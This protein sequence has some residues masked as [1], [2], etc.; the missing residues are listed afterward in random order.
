MQMNQLRVPIKQALI[1]VSDKTGIV[2]FAQALIACNIEI[3]STGG[4]SQLLRAANIPVRDV[5]AV[6]G[7]AEI[8]DGRVK[9]LHPQIHGGILGQRDAHAAIAKTH[10]IDWID[11]VIV[12]LYPFAAAIKKVDATLAEA[13]E[14]I[15]VGGPALIRAAAKNMGWVAV[16]V[17]PNDYPKIL[18]ELIADNGLSFLTRQQ[19]AI[20]AFAY[21]AHYD[22]VIYDYLMSSVSQPPRDSQQIFPAQLNLSLKKF[23]DLRYGEN[24][25]QAACAYRFDN[26]L[27]GVLSAKQYQGKQLSYNNLTDAAAAVACVNEFMQ[28][29]CVVVKHTNPCGAAMANTIAAAF[30]AAFYADS[31]SAFGGIVALNQPCNKGTAEIIASLFI[32][33]LI[34]PAYTDEALVI[35]AGK[36]NLRVLELDFTPP[37]NRQRE[38]KFIEGGVL[39][40]DKD[41]IRLQP[42]DLTVMTTLQPTAADIATLLFAWPVLKQVKS[43]AIII[44]KNQITVGIGAG[45]VSRIDAVD[46]ALKKAGANAEGAILASDA[47]FPFRDSIDRLAGTGVRVIV[48][49]GGS[50]RDQEVIAACNEHSIAM[51]FTKV[52]CFK[53]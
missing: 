8:M 41:T 21:T 53:H 42:Q 19:L 12:N 17:E 52:R 51:V 10:Q 45:Q 32:E 29:A 1:S 37:S 3:I 5:A 20:K 9:T 18:A 35:L 26:H 34:A 50:L 13:I 48:Q 16:V 14:N 46:M 2:E 24:P 43:N 4:T 15:D 38:F 30:H 11:L 7:F 33:V 44:A 25:H 40:Q 23:A 6:T 28:P 39:V 47:F 27:P 49:P 36:Q 22:Q 31:L